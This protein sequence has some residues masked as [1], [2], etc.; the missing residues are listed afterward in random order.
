MPAASTMVWP[1]PGLAAGKLAG[2]MIAPLG[3]EVRIDVA[4]AVGV[5][6]EGDHVGAR[7]EDLL[8]R[9]R[10]DADP[11]RRV[12]AVD[13]DEVGHPLGAQAG[14]RRRQ[15]LPAGLADDVPYEEETHQRR[16]VEQL[17]R[18][19][20][21]RPASFRAMAEPRARRRRAAPVLE[22]DGL[23]KSFGERS[24]SRR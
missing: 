8:R 21:C 17:R 7:L 4:V 15:P 24:P 1:R 11:A 16:S 23:S 9:L 14:H 3:V 19:R 5:V 12:L 20:G 6:A 18:R 13:H 2:R 10:G 22:V